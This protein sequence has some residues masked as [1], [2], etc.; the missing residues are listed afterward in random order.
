M[1]TLAAITAVFSLSCF[2]LAAAEPVDLVTLSRIREEGF[3][4]SQVMTIASGLVDGIGP[5][6]TG[7][8]NAKRANEWTR[9]Q[10]ESMSPFWNTWS[11][12]PT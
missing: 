11:V 6:L 3:K 10:L 2:S 1:K 5:R 12:C 7:S 8:P 4:H 9:T